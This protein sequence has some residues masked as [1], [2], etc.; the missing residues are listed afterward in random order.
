M[1][2]ELK[3]MTSQERTILREL[4]KRLA[5]IA[6]LPVQAE[7][8][9]LWKSFNSLMPKRPMVL[10]YP[11]GG[12]RDLLPESVLVCQNEILRDWEITLRKKIYQ[13]ERIHDDHPVTDFFNIGWVVAFGDYGLHEENMRTSEL[14][15]F[16]W[17]PPVKSCEDVKKLHFRSIQI[18]RQETARRTDMAKQLFGDILRIRTHGPLWWSLG[19]TGTLIKL[20]GLEQIMMDMYDNPQLLH[21][22]MKLLQDDT[23]NFIETCEREKILSEN[24]GSDDFVGSAGVGAT[25]ELPAPDFNGRIRMRDT[26]VL[27]ESQE[28]VGVGPEQFYEFALQYQIPILN[29]FGLVCYGCCEPL[30]SKFDLLI[31]NLPRLRR[32]SVSPWCDRRIAAQKLTDKYIYSWKPNPADICGPSVDYDFFERQI[33]ETLDI[34]KGCCVEIVMK[35]THTFNGDIQRIA[36]WSKIASQIAE[37][38]V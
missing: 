38:S 17:E 5:E 34:A 24:Y 31:K 29:R 1:E 6:A 21:D 33:R 35:D 32:V 23:I 20:R 9:G 11:E 22:L 30:D 36:K 13:F 10:A 4:A 2:Q 3:S 15:S 26:W 18:D 19:M 12:W 25:N 28:M 16:T 37:E 8:I 14:G 27:G 7:R